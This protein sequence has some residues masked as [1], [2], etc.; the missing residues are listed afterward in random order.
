MKYRLWDEEHEDVCDEEDLPQV[1]NLYIQGKVPF[2]V[3][4][5]ENDFLPS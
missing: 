2:F 1:L 5:D 4:K 3:E